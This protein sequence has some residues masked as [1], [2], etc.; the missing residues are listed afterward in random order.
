M[1]KWRC[2]VGSWLWVWN[3][4]GTKEEATSIKTVMKARAVGGISQGACGAKRPWVGEDGGVVS[5][6]EWP[7]Q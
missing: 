6:D 3:P 5:K 4:G 1:C 2:P 7:G